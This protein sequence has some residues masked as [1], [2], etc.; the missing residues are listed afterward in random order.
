MTQRKQQ[1]QHLERSTIGGH[2]VAQAV[3]G[4]TRM[5]RTDDI[6]TYVYGTCGCV[7]VW[8]CR[9][10]GE[11]VCGCVGVWM[12]GCVD[13]WVCGCVGGWVYGCVGVWVCGCVGVWVCGCVGVWMCWCGC[14]DVWVCICG[15]GC[16]CGRAY[17]R[18]YIVGLMNNS[19]QPTKYFVSVKS[20]VNNYV[21]VCC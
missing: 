3:Y 6:K 13:V 10:V 1:Y 11:W 12:C 4:S 19:I 14:V 17:V 8:V 2:L 5:R 7:G 20:I 9:C 15:C 18:A 21:W 16:R